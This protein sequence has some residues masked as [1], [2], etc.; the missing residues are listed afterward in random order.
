[1][2]LDTL[3]IGT[4]LSAW[5]AI[6]SMDSLENVH[7]IDGNEKIRSKNFTTSKHLGLKTKFGSTHSF[8]DPLSL[9][10]VDMSSNQLPAS[11]SRGGLSEVWGNGFTPY[12]FS[13]LDNRNLITDLEIFLSMK[14][15][16]DLMPHVADKALMDLRFREFQEIYALTSYEGVDSHQFFIQVNEELSRKAN[17][18]FAFGRPFLFLNKK[19]CTR[20]GLCLTGCPYGA[21]FDA[22][23]MFNSLILSGKIK[24]TQVHSGVVNKLIPK[25]DSIDVEFWNEDGLQVKSF[26]N[27]ILCAGPIPTAAILMRSNLIEDDFKI[28]D[29]QVFYFAG[30]SM[31]R[32]SPVPEIAEIGQLAIY[33]VNI[34]SG[35][36]QVGFYAPSK[37]SRER[38]SSSLFRGPINFLR[39]PK[40]ISDRL[41]P[42]IGFL[43]QESS[44]FLT[45][46]LEGESII[47][48]RTSRDHVRKSAMHVVRILT[49]L[50]SSTSLRVLK[51][52]LR[53]PDPGSGFH[54]GASIPLDGDHIDELGRLRTE[55][56]IK[57]MDASILPSI[58][59]GAHTFVT[60]ALIRFLMK[61]DS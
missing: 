15:L 35:D 9:N 56:R 16:L 61:K 48:S 53:I 49:K 24:S 27:V 36:F 19:L 5:S 6:T 46:K 8:A 23:E 18:D 31:R 45:L 30:F 32:V 55:V 42:G 28:P 26:K 59:A 13:Q 52:S 51:I 41:I 43:P 20:C 40:F 44:G 4:G 33:P 57:V 54:I 25:T 58:P 29:S 37:I 34:E 50:F 60:M 10:L 2:N 39:V 14:E 7:V 21:L 38:I 17:S 11:L 1:M 47:V 22:G 3:V 12:P